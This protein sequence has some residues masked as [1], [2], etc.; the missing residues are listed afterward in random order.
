MERQ[1]TGS[2]TSVDGC[3]D[4]V[5]TVQRPSYGVQ[6]THLNP[7]MDPEI[8]DTDPPA[9]MSFKEFDCGTTCNFGNDSFA[10][11]SNNS[12]E[13]FCN[14]DQQLN[15]LPI[16]NMLFPGIDNACISCSCQC[17]DGRHLGKSEACSDGFVT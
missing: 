11:T 3:P 16:T 13:M 8:M 10:M 17:F 7:G 6:L 5:L 4:T 2:Q 15:Q 9:H 1:Q 12:N 14:E